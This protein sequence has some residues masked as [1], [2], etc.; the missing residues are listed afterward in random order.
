MVQRLVPDPSTPTSL[1]LEKHLLDS[2]AP[3]YFNEV[4]LLLT[5]YAGRFA[6]EQVAVE[7]V[8]NQTLT[9]AERGLLRPARAF[10]ANATRVIRPERS[11]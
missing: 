2:M 6:T 8:R 4:Q 9:E 5:A 10:S 3:A 11:T 1:Y 7:A